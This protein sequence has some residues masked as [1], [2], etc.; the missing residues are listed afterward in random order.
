MSKI[1][2]AGLL[3]AVFAFTVPII[4]QQLPLVWIPKT[5]KSVVVFHGVKIGMPNATFIAEAALSEAEKIL[6]PEDESWATIENHRGIKIEAARLANRQFGV[7]VRASGEITGVHK[8]EVYKTLWTSGF[9]KHLWPELKFQSGVPSAW[10]HT[11]GVFIACRSRPCE[12]HYVQKDTRI[13]VRKNP[14]QCRRG[15]WDFRGGSV[16]Q[17][18]WRR[19]GAADG[20]LL[21]LSGFPVMP[22]TRLD[23]LRRQG[24]LS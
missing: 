4:V 15:E 24:L 2:A 11:K 5:G 21:R 18:G 9:M 1:L 6:A 3:G 20:A 14:W 19:R 17:R 23:S 22:D 12:R 8:D 13:R 16:A 7:I 10:R